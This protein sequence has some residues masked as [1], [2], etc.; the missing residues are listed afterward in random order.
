MNRYKLKKMICRGLFSLLSGILLILMQAAAFAIAAEAPI[1][2]GNTQMSPGASQVQSIM[3]YQ[4]GNTYTW[5]IQGGGGSLSSDTGERVTYTAPATNP[6]CANN[7]AIS[8]Q[9]NGSLAG[10]QAEKTI[11]YTFHPDIDAKL[12]RTEQS[13]L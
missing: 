9:G 6:D 1:I 11:A 3:N 12:S 7:A 2:N 4:T 8:V 10:T 5:R 13:L